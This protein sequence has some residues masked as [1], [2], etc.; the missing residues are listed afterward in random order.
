MTTIR[1]IERKTNDNPASYVPN[2]VEQ[3][4]REVARLHE[5]TRAAESQTMQLTVSDGVDL[6]NKVK[7]D[8]MTMLNGCE[9]EFQALKQEALEFI[10]SVA[11][12]QEEIQ[13]RITRFT[14]DCAS[15]KKGIGGVIGK[16][17]ERA[18]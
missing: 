7:N 1:A 10:A 13:E 18:K 17:A 14:E 5:E 3:V 15:L 2:H 11:K 8:L 16:I 12:R 9:Q 6:S 4:D